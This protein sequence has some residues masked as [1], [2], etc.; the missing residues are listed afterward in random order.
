MAC[1]HAAGIGTEGFSFLTLSSH[2][3]DSVRPD[4]RKTWRSLTLHVLRYIQLRQEEYL[5]CPLSFVCPK[6]EL[7]TRHPVHI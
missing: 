4:G 3:E 5:R 1:L 7:A 6:S 2:R